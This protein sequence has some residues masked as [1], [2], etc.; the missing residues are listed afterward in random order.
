M[1]AFPSLAMILSL[2]LCTVVCPAHAEGDLTGL[3][4]D[5]VVSFPYVV[6]GPAGERFVETVLTV[7]NPAAEQLYILI[8]LSPALGPF[9]VGRSMELAAFESRQI[10]FHSANT[11]VTGSLLL[12][13]KRP[14]AAD[15]HIVIKASES[16][17]S[18]I[19]QVALPGSTPTNRV[20]FPVWIRSALADNTSFALATFGT[21]PVG[22]YYKASLYDTSG[23]LVR[24]TRMA[25][26]REVMFVT[27][28]FPDLPDDFHSGT[29]LVDTV[30]SVDQAMVFS[31]I[32]LYTAGDKLFTASPADMERPG[33]FG[34]YLQGPDYDNQVQALQAQY[35][36]E[37]TRHTAGYPA[38]TIRSTREVARVMAK[39][40]R[41]KS[42]SLNVIIQIPP[43]G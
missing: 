20:A 2:L 23:Q 34:M 37:V 26:L 18:V 11:L 7:S 25:T 4:T 31:L 30:S 5:H 43:A 32:V 14:F 42:L 33:L 22:A 21:L 28:L 36:F 29:V 39:D 9:V 1:R 40:P 3:A 12:E 17:S 19:S 41:V 13:G 15:A 35:H 10:V 8:S 16:S 24:E 6:T 27:E 38:V